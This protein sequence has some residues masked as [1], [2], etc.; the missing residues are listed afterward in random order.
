MKTLRVA[1]AVIALLRSG[2]ADGG[3]VLAVSHDPIL[4]A[5][6]DRV[7]RLEHGRMTPIETAAAT[8]R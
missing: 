4:T 8:D 6:S 2:C 5:A 7:V 1:A 3:A